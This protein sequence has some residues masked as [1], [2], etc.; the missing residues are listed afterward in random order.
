MHMP[1]TVRAHRHTTDTGARCPLP[2]SNRTY[3]PRW[4]TPD[5]I[6]MLGLAIA[7]VLEDYAAGKAEIRQ[8][9]WRVSYSSI[10]GPS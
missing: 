6:T 4:D 7:E 3:Q 2:A 1:A 8:H 10:A 9:R 5:V